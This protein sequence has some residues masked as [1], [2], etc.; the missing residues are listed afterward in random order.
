MTEKEW[1]GF[2]RDIG[3][4]Q[5]GRFYT[6]SNDNSY[7]THYTS[8][9]NVIGENMFARCSSLHSI[10]LPQ[11]TTEI[12][13]YAFMRC[14]SLKKI[15]IPQKTETLGKKAFLN[16]TSLEK[17]LAPAKMQTKGV[18]CDKCSPIL[19]SITRY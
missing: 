19:R 9:K 14:I 3:D 4:K 7:W 2:K 5:E 17:V 18:A 1:K 12:G 10:I 8:Q 15:T 16:C 13:D 6:R 11:S